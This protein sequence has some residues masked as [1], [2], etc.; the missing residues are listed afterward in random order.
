MLRPNDLPNTS[1]YH[2]FKNGI[3]PMWE[4]DANKHGGKWIVRMRKGLASKYWEDLVLAIIGEQFQVGD[5]LCGAVVSIRFQEDIISIWN[6]SA[7]ST[8]VKSIIYETLKR[9]LS[10]PPTTVLE[11][12][13]HASSI[14]D[15][16][17]FR[18]TNAFR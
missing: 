6:R 2:L 16:S 7:E 15:N 11:Y 18:N 8:V 10:L 1:D 4:D 9:V 5:E 14:Q 17:S 3:K 12:K 13:A